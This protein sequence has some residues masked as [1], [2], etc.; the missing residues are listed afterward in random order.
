MKFVEVKYS[1][2]WPLVISITHGNHNLCEAINKNVVHSEII[3]FA[4]SHSKTFALK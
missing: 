4:V 1:S 2:G 3:L